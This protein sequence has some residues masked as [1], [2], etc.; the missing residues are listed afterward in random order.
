MIRDHECYVVGFAQDPGNVCR[1][2]HFYLND[3][4]H[5]VLLQGLAWIDTQTYQILRVTTLLVGSRKD[6][7]LD[8][9]TTSV[10]FFPVRPLGTDDALW[11]PRD[12]RVE[13]EYHRI[14]IR[15]LHQYSNFKLFR[16][17]STI[18]AG[19]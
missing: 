14:K 2:D 6:I 9:Q 1:P 18:K 19:P 5:V 7:G 13:T 8:G 10:D 4:D 16:V 3:T 15:N 12:V 11:L 17:E